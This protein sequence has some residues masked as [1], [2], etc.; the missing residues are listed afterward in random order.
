MD[1]SV[2]FSAVS[3]SASPSLPAFGML[4]AAPLQLLTSTGSQ[5]NVSDDSMSSLLG[6]SFAADGGLVGLLPSNSSWE[7][8]HMAQNGAS[9]ATP[10]TT[11]CDATLAVSVTAF[12]ASRSLLWAVCTQL[13]S[14]AQ[15]L[16]V[17]SLLG[18]A[19]FA[20]TVALPSTSDSQFWAICVE[21]AA[22]DLYLLSRTRDASGNLNAAL[23]TV[24]LGSLQYSPLVQLQPAAADDDSTRFSSDIAMAVRLN[25]T[26]V[27]VYFSVTSNAGDALRV[28]S[29]STGLP[30]GPDMAMPGTTLLSVLP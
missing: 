15:Q 22:G 24:P 2:L 7:V 13:D 17:V 18:N 4:T 19:S 10:L 11:L 25:A 3:G 6:A 1:P 12:D 27:A 5:L 23:G 28:V 21:P 9:A 8:V 26:D 29:A 30:V 16:A 14:G 20:T